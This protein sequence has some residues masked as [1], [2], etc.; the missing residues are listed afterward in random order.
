MNSGHI[1]FIEPNDRGIYKKE[2]FEIADAE[3]QELKT[4]ISRVA[5]EIINLKFVNSTCD[6]KDCPYCRL[7]RIVKR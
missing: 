4:L 2:S 7:G 3:V 1:D 6:D 5:D